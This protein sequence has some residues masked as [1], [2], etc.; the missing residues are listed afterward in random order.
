MCNYN[1]FFCLLEM[2]LIVFFNYC[3]D[4]IVKVIWCCIVLLIFL[5]GNIFKIKIL[6][7]IL[8]IL[9]FI[10]LFNVV[11]VKNVVL[12]FI[13]WCVILILFSL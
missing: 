5:V 11:I 10:V 1:F 2:F 8:C 7:V 4:G 12:F 6:V 13:K 3:L 9:S